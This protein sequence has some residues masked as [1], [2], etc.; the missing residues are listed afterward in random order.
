MIGAWP[1]LMGVTMYLQQK[2][3]PQPVDPVQARMFML[4]PVVFTYMLSAFPAGLVIYWA[5]NNLLS[6][7][8]QW[9]IMHRA[10]RASMI[11]APD[12]PRAAAKDAGVET[13]ASAS[14]A[15]IRPGGGRGRAAAV[16][17]RMPLCLRRRRPRGPAAGEPAGS[18]LY[19]PLECRQVEPRQRADRPAAPGPH[20]EYAGPH[21]AAQFLRSRRPADA[22]RSARL[23]LC[24]GSKTAIKAWTG[25]VHPYLRGRGTL[26]RACLLLDA[27][28][29]IM[30]AD[31]PILALCDE[32]ALSYQAVLTKADKLAAAA[33][34]ETAETVA[35]ELSPRP[36]AHPEILVTS[37]E[38]NIGIAELRA[39]L[40]EIA[41]PERRG[42]MPLRRLRNG[43]VAAAALRPRR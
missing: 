11:D 10:G 14:R 4:L 40:A 24:R 5:W 2:L 34:R 41:E 30:A 6:I 20:L 7:A 21:A 12:E 37:A 27:R 25:L 16:R 31:R 32:A 1:L 26:R 8:Q 42:A 36:A 18:R 23:W 28:H 38:K 13:S 22:G 39:S 19:R 43:N 9:L 17:A 15:R 29:G 35:A 3:N 33:P